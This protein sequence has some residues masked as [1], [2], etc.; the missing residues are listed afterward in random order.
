MSPKPEGYVIE[1]LKVFD[2]KHDDDLSDFEQIFPRREGEKPETTTWEPQQQVNQHAPPEIWDELHRR[3]MELPGITEGESLISV[4]N[5]VA[6]F[7]DKDLAK[8]PEQSFII[9]NEFAHIHPRPD[10]SLHLQLPL[11]LAVYAISADWAI[12]HTVSWLGLAPAETMMLF[13]PRDEEELE[14]VWSLCEE[15]YRFACGQ[16]AKF[17]VAPIKKSEAGK[18]A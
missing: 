4:P 1:P 11:E 10:S 14:F 6:F 13:A 3:F 15:S 8:G 17:K 2:A 12:L 16:P 7:L 18:A 9:E 5:A